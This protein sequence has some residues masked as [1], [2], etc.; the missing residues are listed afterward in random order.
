[1]NIFR[2]KYEFFSE[3]NEF[4]SKKDM[5]FLRKNMNFNIFV[6]KVMQINQS[7]TCHAKLVN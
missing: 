6:C 4:L 1:M 2:K 3:K 7:H 5:N